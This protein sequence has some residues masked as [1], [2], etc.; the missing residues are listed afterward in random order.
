MTALSRRHGA[1]SWNTARKL[2]ESC[3]FGSREFNVVSIEDQIR[4]KRMVLYHLISIDPQNH[5]ATE[6]LKGIFSTLQALAN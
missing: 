5:T 6:L 3:I 2:L 4:M 1:L